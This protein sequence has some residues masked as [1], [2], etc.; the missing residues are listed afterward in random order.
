MTFYVLFLILGRKLQLMYRI[1]YTIKS[2][3]PFKYNLPPTKRE[4]RS[5]IA[6][7]FGTRKIIIP[8]KPPKITKISQPLLE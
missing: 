8:I 3:K 4:N 5:S 7:Q 6:F 1:V 2:K